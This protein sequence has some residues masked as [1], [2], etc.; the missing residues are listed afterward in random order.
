MGGRGTFKWASGERYDGEWKD[1]KEDG[2]GAYLWETPACMGCASLT[3][4]CATRDV[5]LAGRLLL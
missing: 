5:H 2:R 3:R 1:G 4:S